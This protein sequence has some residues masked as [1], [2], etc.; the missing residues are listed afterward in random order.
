VGDVDLEGTVVTRQNVPEGWWSGERMV[1]FL[2]SDN[3]QR[4]EPYDKFRIL[5]I[6]FHQGKLFGRSGDENILRYRL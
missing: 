5:L 4:S 1:V 6:F 2:K 3:E